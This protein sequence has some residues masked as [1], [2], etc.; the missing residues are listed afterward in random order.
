MGL[1]R[2]QGGSGGIVTKDLRSVTK[3]F[4]R[5][6]K[7]AKVSRWCNES[8]DTPLTA[9]FRSLFAEREEIKNGCKA[10]SSRNQCI[11]GLDAET[12]ELREEGA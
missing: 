1:L 3:R 10:L 7:C 5:P 8:T 6:A 4:E 9:T 12:N 11:S 2:L